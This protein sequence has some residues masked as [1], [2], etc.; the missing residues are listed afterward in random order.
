MPRSSTMT[1][2]DAKQE[3][4]LHLRQD[5]QATFRLSIN[6]INISMSSKNIGIWIGTLDLFDFNQLAGK[7]AF[8]V[9]CTLASSHPN[10]L[11]RSVNVSV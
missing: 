10:A 7:F 6:L 9:D 3:N 8:V 1:L 5:L 2:C 11:K 4:I